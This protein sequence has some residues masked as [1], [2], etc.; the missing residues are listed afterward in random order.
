MIHT[1][2]Y[3]HTVHWMKSKYICNISLKLSCILNE[4]FHTTYSSAFRD[5][6]YC[7]GHMWC[8]GIYLLYFEA[9]KCCFSRRLICFWNGFMY[10]SLTQ[11]SWLDLQSTH[12]LSFMT[13]SDDFHL[14]WQSRL[15]AN[16]HFILLKLRSI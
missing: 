14:Q 11:T 15:K 6:L 7:K 12:L 9:V 2:R 8:F 1:Y 4:M 3:A 5:C 10:Y 16:S 13:V